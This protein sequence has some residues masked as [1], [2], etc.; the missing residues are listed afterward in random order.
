MDYRVMY[1]GTQT[2]VGVLFLTLLFLR[3][4]DR[5]GQAPNRLDVLYSIFLFTIVLDCIW[6]L[7]DGVPEYRGPNTLLQVVYLSA[8]AFTGYFWFLFTLDSFGAR[9]LPIYKYRYLL[10]LPVM[11]EV[12]LIFFSVQNGWIFSIDENSRYVRGFLNIHTVLL[13]YSYMVLGSV[14]A[15]ILRK[16]ALLTIDKRRYAV[17]AFFPVPVL[18]LSGI[19][20]VLPPGVPTMQGGVLVG[21]LLQ[22]G[23]SQQV[24]ITRDYLTG[25]A[26]RVAFEQD[27]LERMHRHRDH[28]EEQL[29]LLEGDLDGFKKVNDTYGHPAGDRALI[30]TGEALR[31]VFSPYGAAVFRVGGDEFMVILESKTPPDV[32]TLTKHLNEALQNVRIPEPVALSMSLGIIEYDGKEDLR[33]LIENVDKKLYAAKG[34]ASV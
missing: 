32:E 17:A 19:Q 5:K 9:S 16:R 26:N 14:I 6:I 21:L 15:L 8:M 7:I 18:I 10:G 34:T 12:V 13:N 30:Q 27:L 4:Y 29:Y 24:L 28:E 31:Q 25:L 23:T 3:R 11:I 2:I 33:S 20:M 22:Y 1:I